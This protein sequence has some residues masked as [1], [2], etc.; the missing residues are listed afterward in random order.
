MSFFWKKLYNSEIN[1]AYVRWPERKEKYIL[2]RSVHW[3]ELSPSQAIVAYYMYFLNPS[4][5]AKHTPL[6]TTTSPGNY[7]NPPRINMIQKSVNQKSTVRNL[8]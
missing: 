3:T 4:L 6:I 8:L 5:R 7:G 1:S 2:A